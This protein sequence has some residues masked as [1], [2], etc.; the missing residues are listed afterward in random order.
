MTSYNQSG[1]DNVI[2]TQF[3]VIT[4]RPCFD[5]VEVAERTVKLHVGTAFIDVKWVHLAKLE[6][7]AKWFPSGQSRG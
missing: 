4:R 1:R 7:S 6:V 3:S 2:M 5:S